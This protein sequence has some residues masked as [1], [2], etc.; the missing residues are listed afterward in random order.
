MAALTHRIA[1]HHDIP[2]VSALMESAIESLQR[3][4]LS[5]E[6]IAASR[7]S[8]GLD[9]QLIADGTYFAIESGGRLA[10]CGGGAGARHCMAAAT[11]QG[12]ATTGCSIRQ[13][14]QRASG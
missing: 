8:M 13:P 2:A 6:K 7:L 9:T 14:S 3:G 10:G 1:T 4:F 5:P 12:C 11:P